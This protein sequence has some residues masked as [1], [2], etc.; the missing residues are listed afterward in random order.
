MLY[1][2]DAQV[3]NSAILDDGTRDIG[4]R[5]VARFEPRTE[6]RADCCGSW[7]DVRNDTPNGRI[8]FPPYTRHPNQALVFARH[9]PPAAGRGLCRR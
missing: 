7:L 9:I 2:A 3:F 5:M 6:R 1:V 8:V 4:N